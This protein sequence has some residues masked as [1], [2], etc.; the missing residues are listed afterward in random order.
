LL[1]AHAQGIE[2]EILFCGEAAKKIAADSPVFLPSTGRQKN[3]PKFFFRKIP[4]SQLFS[5]PPGR[6]LIDINTEKN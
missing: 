1:P 3:A 4:H 5:L 2:A 6:G